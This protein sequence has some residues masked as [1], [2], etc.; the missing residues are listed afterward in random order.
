MGNLD[1]LEISFGDDVQLHRCQQ[2]QMPPPPS[3]CGSVKTS[4]NLDMIWGTEGGE[5]LELTGVGVNAD[6]RVK[7]LI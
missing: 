2:G 3:T 5:N 6:L 1:V 7:I 4:Q